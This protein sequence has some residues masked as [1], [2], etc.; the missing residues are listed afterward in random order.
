MLTW[1]SPREDS[2]LMLARDSP[3][4]L[5]CPR[6][7]QRP[8]RAAGPRDG[9]RPSHARPRYPSRPVPSRTATVRWEPEAL[10]WPSSCRLAAVT[11]TSVVSIGVT[12]SAA[13]TSAVT[14]A[15]TIAVTSA[16]TSAVTGGIA[17]RPDAAPAAGRLRS[18][19][20]IRSG[21][22]CI[23]VITRPGGRPGPAL[24][25]GSP[26]PAGESAGR[27]GRRR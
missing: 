10:H 14:S 17:Q 3:G 19:G 22:G 2:M 23:R 7:P 15:V 18:A 9:R 26:P 12:C 21:G 27:P 20:V 24:A 6:R 4:R 16:V 5:G 8:P 25:E 13:V 1:R 11:V